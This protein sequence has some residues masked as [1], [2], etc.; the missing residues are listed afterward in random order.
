MR[1]SSKQLD[2]ALA[3][4]LCEHCRNVWMTLHILT[5]SLPT[6]SPFMAQVLNHAVEFAGPGVADLS[7]D[8]RL[9]SGV[10]FAMPFACSTH[11]CSGEMTPPGAPL[12]FSR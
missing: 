11:F 3:L 1:Y 2:A 12:L 6:S 7:V 5:T 8:E 10:S 4:F 9:V